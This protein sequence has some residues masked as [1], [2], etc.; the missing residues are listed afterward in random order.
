MGIAPS[1]DQHRYALATLKIQ[2]SIILPPIW[3]SQ[4]KLLLQ[5]ITDFT[6]QQNIFRSGCWRGWCGLLFLD[7]SFGQFADLTNHHENNEGQ[8]NEINQ[9]RDKAA[10]V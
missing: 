9:H 4:S 10:I 2:S 6:K 8:N 1:A 7:Q 3:R 5:G